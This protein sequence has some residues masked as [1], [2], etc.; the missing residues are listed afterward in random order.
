[1]SELVTEVEAMDYMAQLASGQ[2]V[3]F[4]AGIAQ[5]LI[6][7]GDTYGG[8]LYYMVQ[9]ATN[10]YVAGFTTE[11]V[12][13]YDKATMTKQAE[14]AAYGGTITCLAIDDTHL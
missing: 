13:K 6:D 10:I 8:N 4:V 3:D 7:T 9:D 14:T 12:Y 11:K 5:T 2:V 1:M